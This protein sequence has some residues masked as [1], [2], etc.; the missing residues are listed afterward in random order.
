MSAGQ[1]VQAPVAERVPRQT[2]K[3]ARSVKLGLQLAHLMRLVQVVQVN[4]QA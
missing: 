1:I 2:H 3:P 4:G